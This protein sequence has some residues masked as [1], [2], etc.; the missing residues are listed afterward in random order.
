MIKK[1]GKK[2]NSV[3]KYK[4]RYQ[5]GYT[6]G[7]GRT[8]SKDQ[9]CYDYENSNWTYYFHGNYLRGNQTL[10]MLYSYES[11][12]V[13]NPMLYAKKNG[14]GS[15]KRKSLLLSQPKIGICQFPHLLPPRPSSA[16]CKCHSLYLHTQHHLDIATVL[17]QI[18]SALEQFLQS[19]P[20]NN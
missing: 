20:P 8:T 13:I 11:Y 15:D 16:L 2:N 14:T 5:C 19:K 9:N 7:V 12:F 10:E 6:C 4:T 18:V 1:R 3:D 17:P